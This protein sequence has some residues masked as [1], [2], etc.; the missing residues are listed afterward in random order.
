MNATA[1]AGYLLLR[2]AEDASR[3]ARFTLAG[4]EWVLLAD[5]FAPTFTPVT[6]LFTGWLDYPVNGTFLEMGCGAGVTAVTAALSGCRQVTA[7]DICQPSVDNTL[8][9]AARHGVASKVRVLRSDLFAGLSEDERFDMIFWNSS[10][11]ETPPESVQSSPLHYAFFDPGY[12]THRRYLHQAPRHL[13]PGGRL[14]LGFASIGNARLLRSLASDAGLAI[15]TV[16]AERR[17]L[18]H[19]VEFQLLELRPR[20]GR[21]WN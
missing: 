16:R 17:E 11:A 5:V 6:E 19:V 14:L 18:E 21:T 15:T 9:N 13:T 3:P 2:N 20:G 7:I 1:R 4:R 10:F 8:A 12:E